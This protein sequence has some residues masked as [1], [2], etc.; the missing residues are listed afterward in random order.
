MSQVYMLSL[1]LDQQP[2][3]LRSS[4]VVACQVCLFLVSVIRGEELQVLN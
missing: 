1:F 3:V 2:A 4:M